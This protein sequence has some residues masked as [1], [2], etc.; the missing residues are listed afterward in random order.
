M[1]HSND[2]RGGGVARGPMYAQTMPLRSTHR[3]ARMPYLI[4]E[5]GG[6]WLAG[7][8]QAHASDIELPTVVH[9]T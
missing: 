2:G 3:Y 8:V 1:F 7:H 9:A 6:G 5:I 4:S